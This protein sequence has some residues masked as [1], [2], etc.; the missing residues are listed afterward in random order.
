MTE[1]PK[2]NERAKLIVVG[3]MAVIIVLSL[4]GL[5]KPIKVG[6]SASNEYFDPDYK[7]AFDYPENFLAQIS[8][9][10]SQ[11]YVQLF[12]SY[13][14]NEL[15]PRII[16]VVY[17]VD[18]NPDQALEKDIYTSFPESSRGNLRKIE[19]GKITGYQIQDSNSQET[20]VYSYAKSNGLI[21]VFK[22][23]Q[24]YYENNASAQINNRPFLGAYYK[25]LNSIDFDP[26]T[27]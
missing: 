10:G 4:A 13:L 27:Y 20:T 19:I 15:D 9:S 25:I 21:F 8:E 5:I 2:S 12:P 3:A 24:S 1:K 16:E 22:F 7:I 14:E 23:N 11:K 18:T 6:E 17:D 26:I